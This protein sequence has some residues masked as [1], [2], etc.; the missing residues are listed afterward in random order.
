MED[1]VGAE[2]RFSCPRGLVLGAG[3]S[4]LYVAETYNQRIMRLDV[5]TGAVTTIRDAMRADVLEISAHGDMLLAA[6]WTKGQMTL[7]HLPLPPLIIPPST[8]VADLRKTWGD[9]SLPTG[10][11]T[12]IVG[13]QSNRIEHVSK[14]ILSV[15]CEYFGTM[16]QSGL[17]ETDAACIEVPDATPAAFKSFVEYLLT[18]QVIVDTRTGH[19]FDVLQL[20]HKYQVPRLKL[21]CQQAIEA[22]LEPQNAVQL[23]GAAHVTENERLFDQCR[24]YIVQHGVEV[25]RSGGLED[26]E[27]LGVARGLLGDAID[28][29]AHLER[30]CSHLEKISSGNQ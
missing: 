24:Q 30:R 25:K 14:N 11:V 27:D 26:V 8:L 2:A 18:D 29:C 5:A 6:D 15:R 19:A 10:L 28:R 12:F 3:G 21:L 9:S 4:C 7:F 22:S 23:L 17:K 20:A 13:P 1:G 16:F